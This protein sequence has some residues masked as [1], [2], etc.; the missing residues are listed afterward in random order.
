MKLIWQFILFLWPAL[1]IVMGLL[2]AL[3]AN[4]EDLAYRQVFLWLISP[5]TAIAGLV[6]LDKGRKKRYFQRMNSH[7]FIKD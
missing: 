4:R 7:L 6:F 3:K 5:G 1:S 2:S